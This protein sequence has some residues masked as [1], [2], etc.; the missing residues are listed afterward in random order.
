MSD[1][2]QLSQS[3]FKSQTIRKN[4]TKI[5]TDNVFSLGLDLILV[6]ETNTI[7]FLFRD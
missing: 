3:W 4:A 1:H 5:T 7:I 6:W 2:D